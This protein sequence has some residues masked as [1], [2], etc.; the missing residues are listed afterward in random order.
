MN[1]PSGDHTGAVSWAGPWV[2]GVA[3]PPDAGAVKRWPRKLKAMVVPLG[4]IA[5]Y[6]SQS[7]CSSGPRDESWADTRAADRPHRNA[8]TIARRVTSWSKFSGPRKKC[9]R[10]DF[11]RR[12][13]ERVPGFHRSEKMRIS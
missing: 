9:C 4:E 12:P 5:G 2:S 7:G 10:L 11:E 13:T 8:A 1:F 3:S 6:L